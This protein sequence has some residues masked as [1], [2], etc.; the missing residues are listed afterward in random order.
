MLLALLIDLIL[1]SK[2]I[3]NNCYSINYVE[4]TS[5]WLTAE[6]ADLIIKVLAIF[7]NNLILMS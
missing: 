3:K 2:A 4:P 5:F 6:V 1:R 7:A